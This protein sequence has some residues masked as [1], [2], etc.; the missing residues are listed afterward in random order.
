MISQCHAELFPRTQKYTNQCQNGF[1]WKFLIFYLHC[2][3][4]QTVSYQ[5][6]DFLTKNF[7]STVKDRN[8][9]NE[10]CKWEVFFWKVLMQYFLDTSLEH[11]DDYQYFCQCL[12]KLLMWRLKSNNLAI[13]W[14]SNETFISIDSENIGICFANEFSRSIY[15]SHFLGMLWKEIRQRVCSSNPVVWK[16]RQ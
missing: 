13:A 16:H 4:C 7:R 15:G 5:F 1:T 8:F 3:E 2:W 14:A 6:Q 12:L 10:V 11:F 9:I